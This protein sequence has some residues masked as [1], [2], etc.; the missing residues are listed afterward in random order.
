[1]ARPKG[2]AETQ[3]RKKMISR[4]SKDG[5]G[6]VLSDSGCVEATTELGKPSCCLQNCPFPECKL[7]RNQNN[8]RG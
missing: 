5:I 6:Y 1:M 8:K 3:P 2:I 4:G 7:D